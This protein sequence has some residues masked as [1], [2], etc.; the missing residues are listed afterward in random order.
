MLLIDAD[1]RR[2]RTHK[3]FKVSN[4]IGLSSV[5][6]GAAKI[7]DAIKA[8]EV[9]GLSVMVCGPVPPNPAELFHTKAFATVLRQLDEKYDLIVLDSPPVGVVSDAAIISTLVDGVLL[10]LKAGQTSRDQALRAVR[11]MKNVNAR[12]LG[13]VLNDLDLENRSY[14]YYYYG[15][16]GNYY[17]PG[18]DEVVS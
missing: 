10:V 16:H 17:Q 6:V 18:T 1:M 5:I 15:R 11:V 14:D 8:T 9:H 7:E 12:I 2:P 3:I 13:A 4:E